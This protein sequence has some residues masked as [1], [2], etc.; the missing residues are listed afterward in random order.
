M[1]GIAPMQVWHSIGTDDDG[2]FVVLRSISGGLMFPNGHQVS[3]V[4]AG[5]FALE[6]EA[7]AAGVILEADVKVTLEQ[8]GIPH[9]VHEPDEPDRPGP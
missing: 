7:D 8:L 6:I 9:H 3:Y 4:V 5:P 2:R 1:N